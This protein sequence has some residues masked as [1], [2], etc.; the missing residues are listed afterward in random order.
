[1]SWKS[2]SW[3]TVWIA[4]VVLFSLAPV[5][6]EKCA[7]IGKP[8]PDFTLRDLDGDEVSFASYRGKAVILSFFA[9][10]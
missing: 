2:R 8:T 3:R 9:V 7:A 1:M 5:G 6:C 10:G 4:A